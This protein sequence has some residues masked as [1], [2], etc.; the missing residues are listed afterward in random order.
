MNL[1]KYKKNIKKDKTIVDNKYVFCYINTQV[2]KTL[3][4]QRIGYETTFPKSL[5][6]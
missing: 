5:K 1:K 3:D 6:Y 4:Q 2:I